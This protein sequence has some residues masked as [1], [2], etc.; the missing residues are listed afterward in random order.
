VQVAT[1]RLLLRPLAKA[2]NWYAI[3]WSLVL[4]LLIVWW[5]GQVTTDVVLSLRLGALCLAAGMAFVLDDPT[6]ESTSMTPVSLLIR[7]LVR[8]SLTLPVAAAAWLLLG[9]VANG[10]PA[11][12]TEVPAWPFMLELLAFSAVALAGAA[13][14]SR[15][16]GDR[17]GGTA[18]AGAPLLVAAAAAF[19]PGRLRLWDQMPGTSGYAGMARWW[20]AIVLVGG[21]VLVHCSRVGARS[22]RSSIGRLQASPRFARDDSEVVPAAA[23][24]LCDRHRR[25]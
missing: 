25:S 5:L 10:S 6:E 16:L 14:G 2:L 8:I 7:R 23:V 1:A 19:L 12:T 3:L 24:C 21:L 17:L 22:L 15:H 13:I 20:W 9:R 18:G 4:A 11:A